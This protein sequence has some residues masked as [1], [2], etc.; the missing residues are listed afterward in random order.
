[1]TYNEYINKI[2]YF[3]GF[4]S[5]PYLCPAGV[6]SIGYGTTHNVKKTDRV[7][8]A[9]ARS[10]LE[11]DISLLVKQVKNYFPHSN[12]NQQLALADFCYNLG[13]G[14]FLK[15]SLYTLIKTY[16]ESIEKKN[17][18][19][20]TNLQTKIYNKFLEFCHYHHN[21]KVKTSSGLLNRRKFEL[22]LFFQ[23]QLCVLPQ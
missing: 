19:L 10:M 16:F 17:P 13:S 6:L 12:V 3:E 20:T 8:V 9:Q 1:M 11:Y 7:T 4:R 2:T 23:E 14:T 5:R 21:G 22:N 18:T 15:S